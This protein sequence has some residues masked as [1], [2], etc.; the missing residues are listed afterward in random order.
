MVF[1]DNFTHGDLH[2]GN[3][4]IQTTVV[5]KKRPTRGFWGDFQTTAADPEFDG[6]LKRTIVFLDAG[7]TT[8]LD[9]EH[10]RNLRDLFKAVILNDG[11]RAG[12][13]MVERAPFERCSE[14]EGGVDEFAKGKTN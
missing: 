12:R 7:I 2:P 3:V 1:L 9:P 14:K 11:D 5:P 8:S 10:Q 4:L 13:L 6:E